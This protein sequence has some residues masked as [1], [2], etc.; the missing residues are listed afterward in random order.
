MVIE[1]F[2]SSV[3]GGAGGTTYTVTSLEWDAEVEGTLPWALAQA[4]P[5]IIQFAVNGVIEPPARFTIP[6]DTT[7]DGSTAPEPGVCIKGVANV[8]Y[9][10]PA[11]WPSNIIITHMRFSTGSRRA[12]AARQETPA[13]A[14]SAISTLF[15]SLLLA[16]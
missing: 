5:R 3:T 2:G 6:N 7:L 10:T 16:P 1:G 12:T 15:H 14:R 11:T 8:G 9:D 4:G 13:M